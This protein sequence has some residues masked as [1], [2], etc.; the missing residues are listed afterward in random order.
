MFRSI[1]LLMYFF[2][3]VFFCQKWLVPGRYFSL[4]LAL[5]LWDHSWSISLLHFYF[6][7][8]KYPGQVQ[9]VKPT[10]LFIYLRFNSFYS[11]AP[12]SQ[13][14]SQGSH[15]TSP[16][17]WNNAVQRKLGIQTRTWSRHSRTRSFISMWTLLYS[18]HFDQRHCILAE[19]TQ[20]CIDFLGT[21]N[22]I[23]LVDELCPYCTGRTFFEWCLLVV[24]SGLVHCNFIVLFRFSTTQEGI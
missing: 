8:D 18:L 17:P 24:G 19:V 1:F 12:L 10:A 13:Y 16:S 2:C 5:W 21:W 22:D 23:W 6:D 15:G 9:L 7:L 4:E 11:F 3:T 14:R 20:I